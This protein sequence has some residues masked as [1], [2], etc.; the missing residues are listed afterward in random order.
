MTSTTSRYP[1]KPKTL[2]LLELCRSFHDFRHPPP[3]VSSY[4]S[5]LAPTAAHVLTRRVY[6]HP[7]T[8]NSTFK[9]QSIKSASN[10]SLST[11]DSD[12]RHSLNFE[13][14]R[15]TYVKNKA[16]FNGL[17]VL[18][19]SAPIRTRIKAKLDARNSRDKPLMNMDDDASSDVE[20]SITTFSSNQLS[21]HA[22]ARGT[23]SSTHTACTR[24]ACVLSHQKAF[25][26]SNRYDKI[27]VWNHLSET[28]QRPMPTDPPTTP[29]HIVSDFDKEN[30]ESTNPFLNYNSIQEI[31][32]Y[33]RN[34]HKKSTLEQDNDA[35][36]NKDDHY[37]YNE[38]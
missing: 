28:L 4:Q 6:L 8:L 29:L 24:P 17:A 30:D 13:K 23:S 21:L 26:K 22:L 35:D 3:T 2:T 37:I 25:T 10:N 9:Q 15:T 19:S 27:D 11:L 7:L 31:R 38:D 33:K 16:A 36:D 14:P 20:T 34:P 5:Q 32:I 18:S 1:I 12:F